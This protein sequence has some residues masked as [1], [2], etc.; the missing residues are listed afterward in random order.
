MSLSIFKGQEGCLF[1]L[2]DK[3]Y[4]YIG[5]QK[6]KKGKEQPTFYGLDGLDNGDNNSLINFNINNAI[7]ES[8]TNADEAVLKIVRSTIY[9]KYI[10]GIPNKLRI[11]PGFSG[12]A[13]FYE[14]PGENA[15]PKR[16]TIISEKEKMIDP[17]NPNYVYRVGSFGPSLT[18]IK[19]GKI[20]DIKKFTNDYNKMILKK[21]KPLIS[22]T[23]NEPLLSETNNEPLLSETNNEP[24]I[25]ETTINQQEKPDNS[26]NSNSK[27]NQSLN[28]EKPSKIYSIEDKVPENIG[29]R[30]KRYKK[31]KRSRT[32]KKMN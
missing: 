12:P 24:L 27:I 20:K 3:K 11:A 31:I 8:N 21:E 4:I 10:Q 5:L 13:A 2:K 14:I 32:Y 28:S 18:Y 29:G 6:D 9:N 16:L 25:S 23:N 19:E 30:T 17:N 15:T 7:N 22:E 26:L 1:T